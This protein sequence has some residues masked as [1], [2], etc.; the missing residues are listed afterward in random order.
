MRYL[1]CSSDGLHLPDLLVL[2]G[3]NVLE[4]TQSRSS[5][6]ALDDVSQTELGISPERLDGFGI[7]DTDTNE[8]TLAGPV[9]RALDV[10]LLPDAL[11]RLDE[12]VAE[13]LVV[14]GGRGNAQTLLADGDGRVVDGL[15]VDLVLLELQVRG[16]LSDL[17]V[18]HQNGD[19]VGGVRDDGDVALG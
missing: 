16:A 4:N 1:G 13:A 5:L 18:A 2:A 9:G 8:A 11:E 14:A 7:L 15:D 3:E 10:Q 19:D 12:M 17:G 6:H